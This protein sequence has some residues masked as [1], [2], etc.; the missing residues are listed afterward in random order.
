MARS[1]R[2]LLISEDVAKVR[3]DYATEK[4]FFQS[5]FQSHSKSLLEAYD[6]GRKKSKKKCD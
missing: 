3:C 6:S 4:H 2:W 5:H 1:H